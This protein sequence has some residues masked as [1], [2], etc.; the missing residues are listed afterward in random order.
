MKAWEIICLKMGITS[1]NLLFLGILR[2]ISILGKI[3]Y[4]V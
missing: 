4:Q 1:E 2:N 3:I